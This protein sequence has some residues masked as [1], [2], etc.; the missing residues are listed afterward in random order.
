MTSTLFRK[1][2]HKM[3]FK[4]MFFVLLIT[5]TGSLASAGGTGYSGGGGGFHTQPVEKDQEDGYSRVQFV[6]RHQGETTFILKRDG[7][8]HVFSLRPEE[9]DPQM[10]NLIFKSEQNRGEPVLV[11]I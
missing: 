11:E 7:V 4:S 1:P 6:E 5:L 10:M 9:I 3:K 8:E 2:E